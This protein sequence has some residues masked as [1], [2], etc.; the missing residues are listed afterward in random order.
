MMATRM[1]RASEVEKY[2]DTIGQKRWFGVPV[3]ISWS[4]NYDDSVG[5]DEVVLYG[6][7]KTHN[8]NPDNSYWAVRMMNT[9]GVINQH[10]GKYQTAKE[11]IDV[12]SKLLRV[13]LHRKLRIGDDY[14]QIM[15]SKDINKQ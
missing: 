1:M 6:I 3:A 4:K 9:Y 12:V 13:R 15:H 11:A 14:K 5:Y 2:Q 10:C 8:G 7:C